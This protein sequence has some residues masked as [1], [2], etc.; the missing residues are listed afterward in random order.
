ME[1]ENKLCFVKSAL[2]N[3]DSTDAL[4][5]YVSIKLGVLYDVWLD[6]KNQKVPPRMEGR[7]L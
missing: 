6:Q 3:A 5:I 7:S 1:I 4:E 2:L